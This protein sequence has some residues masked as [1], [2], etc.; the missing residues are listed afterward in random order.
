[1]LVG[2]PLVKAEQDRSIRVED[3]PEVVM[4]GSRL[5]Q[6]QQRLVPLEAARHIANANDG[7]RASHGVPPAAEPERRPSGTS[8]QRI[9]RRSVTRRA[10]LVPRNEAPPYRSCR[11]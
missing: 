4:G 1:M 6:A 11:L 7:P 8:A 2:T 5:R 3:L 10:V 9:V